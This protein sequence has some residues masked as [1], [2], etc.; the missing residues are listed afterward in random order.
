MCCGDGMMLESIILLNAR[1]KCLE[2]GANEYVTWWQAARYDRL[3]KAAF[4]LL[5]IR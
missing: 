2:R 5:N 3:E 4:R 1:E